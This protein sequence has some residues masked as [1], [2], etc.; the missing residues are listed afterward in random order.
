MRVLRLFAVVALGVA[1]TW[2]ATASASAQDT[3]KSSGLLTAKQVQELI[4]TAK[5]PAD[6]MKLSKH[7]AALAAKYDA[8]AADHEMVAKAYRSLPTASETKRPGAPDT[9]L[10]CDRLAESARAA[11]KE[12]RELAAAHEHMAAAK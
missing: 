7:F 2:V 12:A 9:A 4:A 8:E 11:A 6:H 3:K 10:H 5:T 1:F